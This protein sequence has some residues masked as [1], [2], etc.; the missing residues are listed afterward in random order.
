M[1]KILLLSANQAKSPYP[2]PPLGLG[3]LYYR[4]QDRYKV[5]LL[6]GIH[7]DSSDIAKALEE[8][9]P[10]YVG[11]SIRN[12]DDMVKGDAHSFLPSIL[13]NFAA[14]VHKYKKAK[15][16]LGGAGFTIFPQEL[17][18]YL[19]AD[20]GVLGEGEESIL[21]LLQKLDCG[22][23]VSDLEGIVERGGQ[24][25]GIRKNSV[26]FGKNYRSDLDLLFDYTP[27]KERGAYPIQT[28]RGCIHRCIYCSYPV[29]EGRHFRTRSVDQIVDEL[30][31][32]SK[33]LTD[34]AQ[35]F[36]FV[37]ST[38]NDPP[39]HAEAI[40]RKIISR[41]LQVNLRTMGMNPVN[42]SRELLEL[43]VQAGFAQIDAT[44]DSASPKMLQ[45]YK[46]N[47]SFKQLVRA[48]ELIRECDMPTMWFF[49]F[50][51]PGETEET[52][53]E[54]FEFIDSHI[55]SDDMVNITE[56]L[57]IYPKTPLADLA[58]HESIIA[59]G[60][61]LLFPEFYVSPHLGE[62]KLSQ[63]ISEKIATRPNC[64]RL[65]DT[66]PPPELLQAALRERKKKNLQEPMFRTLL[67]LKQQLLL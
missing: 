8:F 38:F 67:R 47:F 39:G 30:E 56:G 29:L 57:R 55:F 13:D 62:E 24:D 66:K 26:D 49:I 36:E 60:Q 50:G 17:I 4:L 22:E 19:S 31:Q 16:I 2:V 51:G 1:K 48:A 5:K 25:Y 7:L 65:T 54:S 21:Q 27:Y 35:V 28:K 10:N 40:C 52:L 43:M 37:D 33:R 42:I 53:E 63:I 58:I 44:P 34:P 32:T 46:K 64:I 15:L 12:I 6:D 9:Q 45:N 3:L 59:S 41:N 11:L 20:Y 14:P 23:D 61:S 18:E